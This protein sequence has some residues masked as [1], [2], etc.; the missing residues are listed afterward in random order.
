M[1]IEK[2]IVDDAG[3]GQDEAQMMLREFCDNGFSGNV[4]PAAV[5]LGRP[6]SEINEMLSGQLEIDDDLVMKL[7]GISQERGFAVG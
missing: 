5:A 2:N 7:R 1:E 6:S 3:S 4:E